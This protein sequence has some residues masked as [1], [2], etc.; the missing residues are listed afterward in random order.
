M[1]WD[2]HIFKTT[3]P[4]LLRRA[5]SLLEQNLQVVLGPRDIQLSSARGR[6]FSAPIPTWW[7][8]LSNNIHALQ[9]LMQFFKAYSSKHLVS[10]TPISP[11]GSDAADTLAPSFRTYGR[12]IFCFYCDWFYYVSFIVHCQTSAREGG[13]K[14]NHNR[15]L[16]E[17][18]VQ[19]F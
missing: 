1:V 19:R 13:L 3:S 4:G 18:E 16:T 2:P 9:D 14:S 12:S 5:L 6:V 10:G 15:N 11:W 7:N 17:I 8:S